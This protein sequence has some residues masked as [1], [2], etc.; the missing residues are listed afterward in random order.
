MPFRPRDTEEATSLLA[1]LIVKLRHWGPG[2]G[3][4]VLVTWRAAQAAHVV[5]VASALMRAG[6][7]R[8]CSLPLDK[9]FSGSLTLGSG[10][11]SSSLGPLL[12]AGSPALRS[13]TT[14]RRR[15]PS[16][17]GPTVF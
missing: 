3:Y 7:P 4:V 5:P 8:V 12:S 14:G 6:I 16:R 15:R 17:S 11:S 1:D 9:A 2:S 10:L 13:G